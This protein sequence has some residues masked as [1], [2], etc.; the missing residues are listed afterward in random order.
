[1]NELPKG[2]DRE[3]IVRAVSAAVTPRRIIL[4]GSKA[5]GDDRPDSDTDICVIVDRIDGRHFDAE[6]AIRDSLQ[7]A[8]DGPIDIILCTNDIFLDR[9][10][11]KATFEGVIARE[12][13]SL[14]D[15]S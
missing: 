11:L 8:V 2:I 13:V 12:G 5:R 6:L 4:F 3:A 10:M 15:A 1:M 9:S 7:K 14:Y